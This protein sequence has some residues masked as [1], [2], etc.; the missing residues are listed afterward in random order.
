MF[1]WLFFGIFI[2]L[3]VYRSSLSKA[4]NVQVD[5][6]LAVLTDEGITHLVK[7]DDAEDGSSMN[8]PS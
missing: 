3:P 5:D 4:R 7:V 6:T 2:V 8:M 1:I